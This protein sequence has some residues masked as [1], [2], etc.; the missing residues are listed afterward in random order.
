MAGDAAQPA[1]IGLQFDFR[2]A[3][4]TDEDFQQLGVH[5]HV[6]KNCSEAARA[7]ARRRFR[8]I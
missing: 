5:R 4:G 1:P 7:D 8:Q 3:G 6:K 2:P